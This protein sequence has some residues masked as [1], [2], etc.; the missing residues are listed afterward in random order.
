MQTEQA[1]RLVHNALMQ[2]TTF[3]DSLSRQFTLEQAYD[4]Q[5]ELLK[6]REAVA[7]THA[8]WKVGLTSKAM[9]QQQGVPEPCMGHLMVEGHLTSPCRL[10]FDT[11]MAPGF[12]NELC[13]RLGQPL[14][15]EV[16]FDEALNAIEAVAPAIEVIEKRG[17]FAADLPLAFAG[18]SQQRAFVTGDFHPMST[19]TDLAEIEVEVSVNGVS[20]ERAMGAEVLGSPVNSVVWLAEML[21]RY[22]RNLKPGDLIMSGSFTKQYP[23]AKGDRVC[24]EFSQ[25]GRV[26]IEFG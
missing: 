23:V 24:A 11:L 22:G 8:G 13:L 10:E 9:Q 15:G 12:E 26:E 16:S 7:E 6:Q 3:P 1:A 19:G 25:F 5:F 21:A 20:Q 14:V 4:V 2:N 18:N 17:V